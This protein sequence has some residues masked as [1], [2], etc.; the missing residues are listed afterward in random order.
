MKDGNGNTIPKKLPGSAVTVMLRSSSAQ[1]EPGSP[2]VWTSFLT[3]ELPDFRAGDEII[4]KGKMHR[5]VDRTWTI[6]D[7]VGLILSVSPQ[8]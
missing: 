2:I 7:D 1:I 6:D 5:I 8:L 3:K 4:F